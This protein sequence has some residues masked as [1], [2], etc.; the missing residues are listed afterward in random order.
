MNGP[1]FLVAFSQGYKMNKNSMLKKLMFEKGITQRELSQKTEIARS[2][3]SMHINGRV[4]LKDDEQRR[5][6]KALGCNAADIFEVR[7]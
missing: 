3:L 2:Y 7:S 6:A 4:N 5:I 1:F